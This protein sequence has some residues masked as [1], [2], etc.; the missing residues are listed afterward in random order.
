MKHLR[1]TRASCAILSAALWMTAGSAS[2]AL[3]LYSDKAVFLAQTGA[4]AATTIPSSATANLGAGFTSGSLTFAV[5]GAAIT[6]HIGEWTSR[7]AGQDLAISGFEEF[8]VTVDSG[9][10]HSFGFDF[11]EPETDPNV[12]ATFEDST[13]S[14]TLKN[15]AATV[16]S[17]SFTRPN[18]SAEFVGV[19]TDTGEAFDRVLVR[20]TI[21]NNENEFFG[22]FYTGT[23]A[24]VPEPCTLALAALVVPVM[25]RRMKRRLVC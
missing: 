1:P 18:D 22:Q 25:R 12:N 19:W 20:E 9:L 8:D 7:L 5:A 15:G 16:G 17:F 14:V 24:P 6:F 23:A 2:A 13:F 21:G 3:T 4:T 10:V 11:V